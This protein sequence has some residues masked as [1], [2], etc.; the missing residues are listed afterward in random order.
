MIWI[1]WAIIICI[2][3]FFLWLFFSG[4][5]IPPPSNP[6]PKQTPKYPPKYPPKKTYKKNN[7]LFNS[8]NSIHLSH[9]SDTSISNNKLSSQIKESQIKEL[10]FQDICLKDEYVDEYV[11]EIID[12]NIIVKEISFESINKSINNLN[13]EQKCESIIDDTSSSTSTTESSNESS[14]NE[15]ATISEPIEY[16][17]GKKRSKG[18]KFCCDA[19]EQYYG[20]KFYTVR[21]NFLKNPETK[22]NLELDCYNHDLRLGVEYNGVQHYR[23]PNF[24]GQNKEEFENQ[25]RRDEFKKQMCDKHGVYL[26]SVPYDVLHKDIKNYILERLPKHLKKN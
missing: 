3:I 5:K 19:L 26:I 17:P 15:S 6:P 8:L 7:D 13:I 10:E 21:P 1:I 18:E 25:L 23:W 2:I 20:K 9:L 22:R 11:D 12:D 24:T 14:V 16:G 4:K